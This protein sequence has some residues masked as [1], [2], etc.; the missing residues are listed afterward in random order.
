MRPA[1]VFQLELAVNFASVRTFI[2]KLGFTMVLGFPFILFSMPPRV[3]VAGLV[4]IVLFICFFGAAVA[5]VRRRND[6][7]MERL[8]L[9]PIARWK[10]L[11]DFLLSTTAA[12]IIQ[13]SPLIILFIL[14]HG[15]QI[16]LGAIVSVFGMLVFTV[17]FF[18]LLGLLLGWAM[19][20]NPEVHLIG[21]LAT[22]TIAFISG[23]L[24]V[25]V[26]VRPVIETASRWSPLHLLSLNLAH[27]EKG[28]L[29]P[30]DIRIIFW[31]SFLAM[32]LFVLVFRSL[33]RPV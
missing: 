8:K 5:F 23:I 26:R 22:A 27:M 13:L 11:A 31:G 19:R 12:D 17:L 32:A 10:I 16:G 24:P 6:G 1:N 29:M 7:I 4:M 21:A 2:M 33:N 14:V 9:L 28:T 3:Q 18:N 25:P 15:S 30:G 20:S